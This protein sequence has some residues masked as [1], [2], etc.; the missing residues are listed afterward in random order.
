VFSFSFFEKVK[1]E[2]PLSKGKVPAVQGNSEWHAGTSTNSPY[3]LYIDIEISI[4]HNQSN[5]NQ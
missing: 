3:Q 4:L 5:F 1:P 2:R